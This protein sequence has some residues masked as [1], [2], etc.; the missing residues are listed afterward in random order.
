MAR[1]CNITRRRDVHRGRAKF[2]FGHFADC[3]LTAII[4]RQD[5]TGNG[6]IDQAA[7]ESAAISNRVNAIIKNIDGQSCC[8][9][10]AINISRLHTKVQHNVIV[11]VGLVR[12]IESIQQSKAVLAVRLCGQRKHGGC[13][14]FT[15]INT[16]HQR[17]NHSHTARS[18]R[19]T[20]GETTRVTKCARTISFKI[21]FQL[22]GCGQCRTA[23]KICFVECFFS[24][25]NNDRNRIVIGVLDCQDRL[26]A[27]AIGVG[28]R[29]GELILTRRMVIRLRVGKRTVGIYFQRAVLT[30]HR[31]IARCRNSDRGRTEFNF[32]HSAWQILTAIIIGQNVTINMTNSC[33][34]CC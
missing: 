7:I 16:A 30:C 2:N 19:N 3:I 34:C 8:C 20:A 24:R 18:Q 22:T 31:H 29:I 21:S 15:D 9:D 23:A 14:G 17:H 26:V 1:H 12:M 28:Q 25:L 27:V 4:V 10:I 13:A 5:I 32:C 11:V 33:L 6:V